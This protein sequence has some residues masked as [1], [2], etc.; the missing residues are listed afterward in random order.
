MSTSTTTPE[1]NV[2]TSLYRKNET[3]EYYSCNRE[4]FTT[5]TIS[6]PPLVLPV[7]P[8]FC[9]VYIRLPP[10]ISYRQIRLDSQSPFHHD[11]PRSIPLRFVVLLLWSHAHR[12]A[13]RMAGQCA[14]GAPRYWTDSCTRLSRRPRST[15]GICIFRTMCCLGIS[16]P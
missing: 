14:Q 11:D 3:V 9:R 15:C 2:K 4:L 16:E 13:G 1:I 6:S 12:T 10:S 5:I 8:L 7:V